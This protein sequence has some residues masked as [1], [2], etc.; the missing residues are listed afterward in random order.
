MYDG[1]F[2]TLCKL[3]CHYS[4]CVSDCKQTTIPNGLKLAEC[5]FLFACFKYFDIHA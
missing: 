5:Y 3:D 1:M 2:S 4:Y